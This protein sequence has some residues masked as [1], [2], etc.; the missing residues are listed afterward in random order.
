MKEKVEKKV[1]KMT[2]RILN[3]NVTLPGE[4]WPPTCTFL[5]HQPKRPIKK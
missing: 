1:L 5:I 3:P 4:E 2:E